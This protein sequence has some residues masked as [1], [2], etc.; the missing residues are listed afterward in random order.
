MLKLFKK[1]NNRKRLYRIESFFFYGKRGEIF[2]IAHHPSFSFSSETAII[3]CNPFAEEKLNSHRVFYNYAN[4]LADLGLLV[5]RFDYL[6]TGDS[7]GDFSLAS[8]ESRTEDIVSMVHMCRA[9]YNINKIVLLGLRLGANLALKALSLTEVDNLILWAPIPDPYIYFFDLLRANLTT[10]VAIYKRILKE[11]KQLLVDIQNGELVNV[12][13]YDFHWK[14]FDNAHHYTLDKFNDMNGVG[15]TL[16]LD[17][18]KNITRPTK[19]LSSFAQ[20]HKEVNLIAVQEMLFWN[21]GLAKY[22]VQPIEVF[23]ASDQW[24]EQQSIILRSPTQK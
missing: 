19:S 6:G 20:S 9:K 3:F 4:R 10:Q 21:N 8:L 15:A 11:R 2:T 14:L 5:L 24:L 16:I 23:N 17:V 7:D 22:I 1:K 12:D 18:V 13:G